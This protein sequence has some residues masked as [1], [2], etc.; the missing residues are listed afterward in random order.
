MF[1]FGL[2]F[3]WGFRLEGFAF[4]ATHLNVVLGIWDLDPLRVNSTPMRKESGL[5]HEG[6]L[7]GVSIPAWG[8]AIS[9]V[10]SS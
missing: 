7:I 6:P 3:G 5:G 1:A 10:K 8:I 2:V 4:L 9:G